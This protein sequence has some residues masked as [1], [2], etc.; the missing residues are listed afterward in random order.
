VY[1]REWAVTIDVPI[2]SVDYSLAPEAPFP[3]A[4]EECFYAFAWAVQ[5]CAQLGS[6]GE[7]IILVGDSAGGNLAIS[8]AMRAVSFGIRPPDGILL[9]YPCTVARYTPSPARLLSLMD[10]ILP[11]GLVTRCLAAYAGIDE[12]Q[13]MASPRMDDVH[14]ERSLTSIQLKSYEVA[15]NDWVMISQGEEAVTIL[16]S[17]DSAN[18][19]PV[20]SMTGPRACQHAGPDPAGPRACQH[21]GPDPAGPRDHQHTP[22]DL[23]VEKTEQ[24]AT[25]DS[26]REIFCQ[27]E[28][29]GSVAFPCGQGRITSA[30]E[31]SKTTSACSD[32]VMDRHEDNANVNRSEIKVKPGTGKESNPKLAGLSKLQERARMVVEGA[33]SMFSKVSSYIPASR[34]VSAQNVISSLSSFLPVS[35]AATTGFTAD[36]A[37]CQQLVDTAPRKQFL[38]QSANQQSKETSVSKQCGYTA[39]REQLAGQ[40]ASQQPVDI[41]ARKQPADTAANL[42]CDP[43]LLSPL[44]EISL[45]SDIAMVTSSFHTSSSSQAFDTA[46]SSPFSPSLPESKSWDNWESISPSD[47]S[48]TNYGGHLVTSIP[49]TPPVVDSVCDPEGRLP[50]IF[51][52]QDRLPPVCDPEDRLPPV[53]DPEDRLPPVCD[54]EDRLPPVCDPEDRLPPVC[55]PEDRLPPVCDPEG[56]LP[57]I[58]DPQERLPP[59]CD[60]EDRLS[61]VCDPEGRLPS[62]SDPQDRLLSVCD[63]ENR[64]P[65]V[66]DPED[67]LPSVCDPEDRLPSVCDPEDRL[68]S[69]CDPE[70]RLPSDCD[71]EDRLPSDCDPEDRLPSDCDS[72]GRLPSACDPEDR[73][74][75]ACD[76]E[77]RLPSVCGGNRLPSVCGGNRLPADK[78]TDAQLAVL[79]ETVVATHFSG[80]ELCMESPVDCDS[81][82]IGGSYEDSCPLSET[83][84]KD[85]SHLSETVNKDNSHLSETVNKDSSHL[86]ETVN[87]DNSHLSETVNKDSSHLSET[88]NKD[89]S[90]L[91]ETVNKDNSH[92]SETVNKD[93]SLLPETVNKDQ[94]NSSNLETGICHLKD[95]PRKPSSLDLKKTTGPHLA[96]LGT[97]PA[98]S[99]SVSHGVAVPSARQGTRSSLP[100]S[101]AVSRSDGF[102]R[103]AS[104]P[105][106]TSLFSTG[107]SQTKKASSATCFHHDLKTGVS[108]SDFVKQ[109][110]TCHS[111]LHS[112]R[113]AAVVNNPYMSPLLAPD[114]LLRD[115]PLVSIVACHLDPLLDDSIMFARRLHNLQ[116]SVNL[117][118]VDDL[119][120]GFL[121]FALMSVEAKQAADLCGRQLLEMLQCSHV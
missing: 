113:R 97:L 23:A 7:K 26:E 13:P 83:V 76:P 110:F 114:E 25:P 17:P 101:P 43:E 29:E 14:S 3:R 5:N 16:E 63:P 32:Q 27:L 120:H 15:D 57:S 86:S 71:P 11:V 55:D 90:H 94:V 19:T 78:S 66:C 111:P 41:A 115:L 98:R 45:D 106:L 9:V 99:P 67:R 4:L 109:N 54:P 10:P 1:L 121:N 46:F 104:L 89:S 68:P 80:G 107:H 60:P 35:N 119:P 39:A 50:S 69:V 22:S 21:A 96:G 59:V 37:S 88:V 85:S 116:V 74:P 91:S 6:T 118:L 8:T 84:N 95:R 20:E 30:V 34:D 56:R 31:G 82:Y 38:G 108:P 58:S 73:L 79:D 112:L 65:S 2:L 64:L 77:G 40:A 24:S 81:C 62:V 12:Q 51:D 105:S 75:S 33:Q 44:D 52:P 117:H 49:G 48:S 47:A 28:C 87:K 53:C 72:E 103:H 93:R 100:S 102:L 18:N 70:D 42:L 36:T 92:L 61:S